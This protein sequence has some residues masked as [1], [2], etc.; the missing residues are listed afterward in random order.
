M[1][2]DILPSQLEILSMGHVL[3]LT[4]KLAIKTAPVH[5]ILQR[6][7]ATHTVDGN[8]G[9]RVLVKCRTPN[10]KQRKTPKFEQQRL[11]L[12]NVQS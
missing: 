5:E 7:N 3:K 4:S 1:V 12:C 10:A 11:T 6:S 2:P 8:Y 9:W